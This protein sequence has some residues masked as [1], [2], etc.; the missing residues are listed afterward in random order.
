MGVPFETSD[1]TIFHEPL[2]FPGAT[3]REGTRA[4]KSSGTGPNSGGAEQDVDG[5]DKARP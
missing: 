3:E 4:I 2:E 1:Q 5:R